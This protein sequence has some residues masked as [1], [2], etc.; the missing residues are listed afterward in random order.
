MKVYVAKAGYDYEGYEI[1][2]IYSTM[3]LAQACIDEIKSNPL[4]YFDNHEIEEHEIDE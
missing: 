1:M 3:E 4:I 2:G